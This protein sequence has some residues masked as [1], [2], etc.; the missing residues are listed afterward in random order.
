LSD[1]FI[2]QE[3][4][5]PFDILCPVISVRLR[6]IRFNIFVGLVIIDI[7][8][9]KGKVVKK[10]EEEGIDYSDE[11]GTSSKAT[12]NIGLKNDW[13]SSVKSGQ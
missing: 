5:G 6:V 7:K 4:I 10:K 9:T 2:L 1:Q 3:D 12:Q 11:D 13:D 8:V